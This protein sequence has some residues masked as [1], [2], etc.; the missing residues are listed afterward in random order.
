MKRLVLCV[1]VCFV[2]MFAVSAWAQNASMAADN[3][4]FVPQSTLGS[5]VGK[6]VSIYSDS[7]LPIGTVPAYPTL[8]TVAS[9]NVPTSYNSTT[10]WLI[11]Q[12]TLQEYCVSDGL[13][14]VVHAGGL[15]MYPDDNSAFYWECY[16]NN[17]YETRTRTWVFPAQKLGGPAIPKVTSTVD[18]MVTSG[19]GTAVL[20]NIRSVI[21]QAVK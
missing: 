11:V 2:L 6:T 1:V 13:A 4:K 10:Q 3:Q 8:T 18:V 7:S 20:G 17:G 19:A 9:V 12:V 21:V 5:V 15:A 14:T 16:H